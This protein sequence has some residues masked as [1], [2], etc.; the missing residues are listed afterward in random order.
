MIYN[1]GSLDLENNPI[2]P[3]EPIPSPKPQRKYFSA[4]NLNPMLRHVLV[5]R[6]KRNYRLLKNEED[7]L[8]DVFL[9]YREIW[10][11]KIESLEKGRKID[12]VQKVH[13]EETIIVALPDPVP[14]P[15]QIPPGARTSRNSGF[16]S[17]TVRSEAEWVKALSFLGIEESGTGQPA[18]NPFLNLSR[19]KIAKDVPMLSRFDLLRQ[20]TFFDQN[21]LV[22]DPEKE[23]AEY[24]S[25]LD[26]KWSDHDCAVFK[27]RLVQEGKDFVK[28]SEYLPQKNTQDCVLY[29]YREKVNLRFKNLIRRNLT[30]RGRR[31][32]DKGYIFNLIISDDE[33]ALPLFATYILSEDEEFVHAYE[34]DVEDF[35]QAGIKRKA[36]AIESDA[37]KKA[38]KTLAAPVVEDLPVV[39]PLNTSADQVARKTVSYWSVNERLEFLKVL[40]TH[41]KN[42]EAIA[43]TLGSKSAI[44]VRNYFHNS[45]RKLDLDT[46]LRLAGHLTGGQIHD[47]QAQAGAPMDTDQS[48]FVVVR[49]PS[50]PSIQSLGPFSYPSENPPQFSYNSHPNGPHIVGPDD[51]IPFVPSAHY[52][53]PTRNFPV[54]HDMSAH[55][56]VAPLHY[57]LDMD[58]RESFGTVEEMVEESVHLAPFLSRNVSQYVPHQADDEHNK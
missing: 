6:M 25:A 38:K 26:V 4:P 21:F 43:Q 33:L 18:H 32:K 56:S 15:V 20:Q 22:K 24:N 57:P 3:L 5:R 17:D 34:G 53:S 1:F 54:A 14:P 55:G 19:E 27:T 13:K 52:I 8:V 58:G 44:Q 47:T 51:F 2:L 11:Y 23:L 37:K 42:F 48:T 49:R 10:D 45:R 7:T 28:I 16:R 9:Q 40:A 12:D 39:L 29:Y 36:M 41:G 30:G 35:V 31:K 46:V 50:I